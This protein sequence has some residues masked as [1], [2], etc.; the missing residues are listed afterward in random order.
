MKEREFSWQPIQPDYL[1]SVYGLNNLKGL[2]PIVLWIL[3]ITLSLFS[4]FY[5]ISADWI[6]FIGAEQEIVNFFIINPAL[7]IAVLLFFW[8]GFEWGFVPLFLSSFII[9]FYFQMTWFWA[10][11]IGISF[12]L[13]LAILALSYQSIGISYTLRNMGSVAFFVVVAFIASIASSM[14]AF[15]WS[16]YYQLPANEALVIWQSWWSGMFLQNLIIVAPLLFFF[17]PVIERKKREYFS[18]PQRKKVSPIW[19]YGS[20]ITVTLTLILFVY[21]AYLLGRL[22][23]QEVIADEQIT[24][25]AMLEA[26]EAFEIMSWTSI[27]LIIITGYGAI[28]LMGNWNKKLKNEVEKHTK[29]LNEN[30][31]QLEKLVEEKDVLLKEVHHRV[32]N[33]LAQVYAILELQQYSGKEYGSNDLLKLSKSRVRSMALAHEALYRNNNFSSINIKEYLKDIAEATHNSFKPTDKEIDLSLKLTDANI[34]MS[35]AIPLGLIINEILINAY[36][37]AFETQEDGVIEI[38]T[39]KNN[40]AFDLYVRDNG[41][42]MSTNSQQTNKESFGMRLINGLAEQISGNVKTD[43][44]VTGTVYKISIPDKNVKQEM[45]K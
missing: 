10:L 37:H 42:G 29:E 36:Q 32:K 17:S 19:I 40:G 7:I 15:I 27:G 41:G 25:S 12:V 44:D 2:L 5:I 18:M 6:N 14:G 38:S 33:N 9:A 35:K 13:G 11:L 34:D 45:Q 26:I 22:G 3:L 8:F 20:V 16:F 4:I 43:S 1:L 24:P 30:K 31:K 21:S 28:Y 39:G 23:I